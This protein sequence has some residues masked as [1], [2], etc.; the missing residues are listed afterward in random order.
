MAHDWAVLLATAHKE[1]DEAARR[2]FA[3]EG[4]LG[5]A[6]RAHGAA[7]EKLPILAAQVAAADRRWVGVEEQWECLDHELTLLILHGSEL[8]MTITGAPPQTPLTHDVMRFAAAH[9]TE[10]YAAV[11]TL[12]GGVSS[13]LVHTGELTH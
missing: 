2:V 8:C 12:G 3:L 5:A 10:V 11:R 4:E 1:A 9:H 6:C 13:H 7:E